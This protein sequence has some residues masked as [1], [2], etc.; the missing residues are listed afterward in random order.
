MR[1]GLCSLKINIISI[2]FYHD[3]LKKKLKYNNINT[4]YYIN[5]NTLFSS[6]KI[7]P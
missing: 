3:N 1:V 2:T 5:L 6:S 4:K 7:L